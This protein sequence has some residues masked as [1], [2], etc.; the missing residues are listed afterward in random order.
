VEPHDEIVDELR[1]RG[2]VLAYDGM[3]LE[4]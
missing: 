1:E 4:F 2:M 3:T